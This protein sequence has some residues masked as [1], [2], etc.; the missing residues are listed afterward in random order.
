MDIWTHFLTPQWSASKDLNEKTQKMT[1][2]SACSVVLVAF[3]SI[4]VVILYKP[5]SGT[6]LLLWKALS[7]PTS[8]P[9]FPPFNLLIWKTRGRICENPSS[10][11]VTRLSESMC[12]ELWSGA[13]ELHNIFVFS[14]SIG[15]KSKSR[16]FKLHLH[17]LRSGL[18]VKQKCWQNVV[19]RR[20]RRRCLLS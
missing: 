13:E 2:K 10:R 18:D 6:W 5:R 20:R 12:L 17:Q 14:S 16:S 7:Q 11:F 15:M 4:G 19:K 1:K 8:S 9:H 3:F